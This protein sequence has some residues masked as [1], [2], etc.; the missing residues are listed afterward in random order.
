MIRL[1]IQLRQVLARLTL[2]VLTA[3]AFGLILLGK[4]DAVIAEQARIAL[5]DSLTPLFSA[6]ATPIARLQGAF[7][8]VGEVFV[9]ASDNARLREEN[10]ELRKWQAIALALDAENR[11]LKAAL[12]WVPQPVPSFVTAR[13][14]ADGGG[15]YV[16]SVLVAVGAAS[17]V[18][19]GAIALDDDGLLG[20]VTE[21][22]ARSARV[23]LVTDLNSRVP[24]TLEGSQGRAIMV[25]TNGPRPRLEYVTGGVRP[26]EGERIVTSAVAGVFPAG[27]PVGTVH[28]GPHDRPEVALAAHIDRLDIV[29]LFDFDLEQRLAPEAA[30]AA[31]G[32]GR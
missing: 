12:H 3:V 21:V 22:G 9:L 19:K 23:L 6:L 1:S 25:G 31:G 32:A 10:S 28:Y 4:A 14:I 13:A 18:R 16:R 24:V 29:R 30:P 5:G 26:T 11:Q 15:L 7:G 8:S 17:G 20:R 2:P 27:L